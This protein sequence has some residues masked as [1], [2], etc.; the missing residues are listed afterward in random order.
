VYLIDHLWTFGGE[1]EARAHLSD[2]AAGPALRARLA[3]LLELE[4]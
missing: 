4:G 2:P 3:G 1:A